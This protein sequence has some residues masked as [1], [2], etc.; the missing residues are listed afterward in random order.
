MGVIGLISILLRALLA[1]RAALAVENLA[2]RQRDARGRKREAFSE[3]RMR[4][5]RPS[6]SM[7]GG[8]KRSHE[9]TWD[10]GTRAK[11]AG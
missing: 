9:R 2:L 1:N 7:S 4:E 10:T 3:S 11:A 5:N 8:W 6:G